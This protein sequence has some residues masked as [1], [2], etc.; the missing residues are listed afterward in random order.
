MLSQEDLRQIESKGITEKQIETQLEEFKTGFPFLKLEA[1][2]A[3]GKGII[4]PGEDE[5][6]EYVK[7]WEDY[8]ASGKDIV[9]FVPASGAP[10]ECSKTCSHSSLQ[11]TTCLQLHLR[12]PILT[13]SGNSLSTM[14]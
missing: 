12:K 8:K 9:K 1:A 13:T 3:I 14:L 4:A 6:K 2:A 11:T 7:A 10:A 5:L